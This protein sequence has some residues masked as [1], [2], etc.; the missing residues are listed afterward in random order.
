[1]DGRWLAVSC[2]RAG[3][4]ACERVCLYVAATLVFAA[5]CYKII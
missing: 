2:A 3:V 1:M 5:R 4:S